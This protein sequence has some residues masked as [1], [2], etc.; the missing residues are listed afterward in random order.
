VVELPD[1]VPPLTVAVPPLNSMMPAPLLAELPDTVLPLTVSVPP[2]LKMPPPA[3][4]GGGIGNRRFGTLTVSGSTLST[5]AA[6][7]GKGGAHADGRRLHLFRQICHAL[8]QWQ[9]RRWGPGRR[10]L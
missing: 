7:V 3:G 1:T 8:R 2:R 10:D 4:F 6:I 9:L 5:N